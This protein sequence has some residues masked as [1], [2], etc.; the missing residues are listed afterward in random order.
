MGGLGS[1][2]RAESSTATLE[3]R[4]RLRLARLKDAGLLRPGA[5][6]MI[7]AD[8][9]WTSG[10][11]TLWVGRFSDHL[12]V[13]FLMGDRLRPQKIAIQEQPCNFGGS[14]FYMVCPGV[15]G[16]DCGHRS[17]DLYLTG[18]DFVCRR[19]S[20]SIYRSQTIS[21]PHLK[22]LARITAIHAKMGLPP[23]S[24]LTGLLPERPKNMRFVTYYRAAQ[25]LLA[26]SR[27]FQ[28][29]L[30]IDQAK[31]LEAVDRIGRSRPRKSRG[32]KPGTYRTSD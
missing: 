31:M 26:A 4:P 29:H 13:C 25:A 30:L 7:F 16:R 1:G 6:G 32:G 20:G 22:A 19:C 12:V 11:L 14:R 3:E 28:Q 2:R 23:G 8:H 21:A 27:D 24:V 17:M 10:R 9:R 15:A 5:S 18:V